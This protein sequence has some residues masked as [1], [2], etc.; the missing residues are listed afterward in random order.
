MSTFS[1]SGIRE[2]QCFGVGRHVHHKAVAQ[3]ACGAQSGVALDDRP[4][5][6]VGV[7]ASLHQRLGLALAH[8]LDRF[9]RGRM[10]EGR[11]HDR[12][13]REVDLVLLRHR[14]DTRSRAHQDRLDQPEARRVH[15]SFERGLVAG[16]RD[17]RWRGRQRLAKVEETLIFLVGACLVGVGRGTTRARGA[18]IL[19]SHG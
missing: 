14:L 12:Q 5:Q 9:L 10:T 17:C 7:Q 4:H 13:T 1:S 16:M 11:V 18:P 19:C 6:L 3:P 2:N 15:R 8:Q